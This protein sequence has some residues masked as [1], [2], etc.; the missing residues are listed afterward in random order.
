MTIN[1]YKDK[2]ILWFKDH[3]NEIKTGAKCLAFGFLIGVIKGSC[4]ESR[5]L[6]SIIQDPPVKLPTGQSEIFL[7]FENLGSEDLD[8]VKKLIKESVGIYE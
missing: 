1:D 3:K 4:L 2:A 7:W 5:N 6:S 8:F